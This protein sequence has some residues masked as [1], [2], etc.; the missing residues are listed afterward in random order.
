MLTHVTSRTAFARPQR[1]RFHHV[2]HRHG[3]VVKERLCKTLVVVS[4]RKERNTGHG[5]NYNGQK[6]LCR[7]TM[8][9]CVFTASSW[10]RESFSTLMSSTVP[11]SGI[12]CRIFTVQSLLNLIIWAKDGGFFRRN[13]RYTSVFIFCWEQPE[14]AGAGGVDRCSGGVWLY[15]QRMVVSSV[16]ILDTL[17][18]YILLRTARR[19]TSWGR[20]GVM[21]V[22]G[23]ADE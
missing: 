21:G 18:F 22:L 8:I 2:Y 1:G 12:M 20:G 4:S 16:A 10:R 13:F 19:C 7:E 17:L 3:V 14:D 6:F 9:G 23:S 11:Y 5:C 15:E